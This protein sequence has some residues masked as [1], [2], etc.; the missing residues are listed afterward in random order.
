MALMIIFSCHVISLPFYVFIY[1]FALSAAVPD[2][3][4]L[5]TKI[6][7]IMRAAGYIMSLRFERPVEI[8]VRVPEEINACTTTLNEIS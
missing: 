6:I 1:V 4:S 3:V 2:V 7:T 5:N 8:F